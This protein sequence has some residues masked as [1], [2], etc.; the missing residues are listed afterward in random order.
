MK[1]P[2]IQVLPY[3]SYAE[4]WFKDF[5]KNNEKLIEKVD[6]GKLT[7]Y[8]K[9]GDIIIFMSESNYQRWCKGMV[10]KLDG[11]VYRSGYEVV[12]AKGNGK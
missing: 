11:K 7:I 12:N 8:L 5:V 4:Y 3:Y 2:I 1:I 10:Y 6:K 9:S